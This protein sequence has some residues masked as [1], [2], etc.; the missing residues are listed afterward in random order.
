M[1]STEV[2]AAGAD[3]RSAR[4][5]A[6]DRRVAETDVL[7][8]GGGPAGSTAATLLA[9]R[10]W[11]VLLLEK[12][13]HP[14]FHIGESL[15]P[16]NLP[17]FERLGVLEQVRAIGV[18]KPGA[19]FPGAG[20]QI[21]T[22]RFDRAFSPRFTYGF[23]VPRAEFDL[24]LLD[25]ARRNG[26]D[27]REEV[28]VRT[29]EW[30]GGRPV[31]ACAQGADG[32]LRV[33]MRYLVD[34]SGRDTFLGQALGLKRKDTQHASAALFSHFRGVLHRAGE[35]G[36]NI[37]VHRFD[38]GWIWIIPLPGG[39]TSIGVVGAPDFMRLR[40]G[41]SEGLLMRTLL[42][43]PLLAPRLAHA[44]R[45]GPV[46]VTGNYS[47]GSRQMAGPGWIMAGD[48]Y[49]FV[50]PV[51]SSGVYLA[52]DS[53][54]RATDVVDGALRD[55]AREPVLQRAM[56]RRLRRGLRVFSWFIYRFTTPGMR[57]LFGNPRNIL[58]VERAVISM[59]AG[60][61]FDSGPVS[62]R[63]LVFR[64]LYLGASLWSA[65]KVLR[66]WWRRRAARNALFTGETL[67][68]DAA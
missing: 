24:L 57:H 12:Q 36:G 59:L 22:F 45:T 19:D 16:M 27:V 42:A 53:A 40:R 11:R 38:H 49:A 6:V 50:D 7:V 61:V 63:L 31:R 18:H 46:H 9:R 64:V 33:T 44:E 41:D 58:Q 10:G 13:R 8:V 37:A 47:Y 3:G 15:L 39:V 28:A 35:D 30:E 32:G 55:P 65:P 1:Q 4:T 67:H 29:L 34:A 68:E 52:M 17:I 43:D 48:A 26:V 66:E 25:H 14:R 5:T 2:E 62:R 20:G 54:E 23:Q 60:D 21:N 51:F 56:E